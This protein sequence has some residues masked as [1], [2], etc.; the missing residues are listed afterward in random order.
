MKNSNR[1]TPRTPLESWGRGCERE[2][3]THRKIIFLKTQLL[4]SQTICKIVCIWIT[5]ATVLGIK[6]DC[7][8][9]NLNHLK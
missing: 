1:I 9:C 2:R 6:P 4:P 3:R 8:S 7:R 5:I